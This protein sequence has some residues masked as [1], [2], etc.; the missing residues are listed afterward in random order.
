MTEPYTKAGTKRL[1][2]ALVSLFL[3]DL[4]RTTKS[5]KKKK[6]NPED[7]KI[8]YDLFFLPNGLYEMWCELGDINEN[9]LR[10]R[11]NEILKGET[12]NG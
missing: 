2:R 3:R 10:D 12:K 11:A 1:A 6:A 5:T 8:M 7:A 9:A 4:R